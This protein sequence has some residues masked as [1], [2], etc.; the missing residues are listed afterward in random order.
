[1]F[2]QPQDSSV[3]SELK[4]HRALRDVKSEGSLP[5][6][7]E[8]IS[9]SR[10]PDPPGKG[11]AMLVLGVL[12]LAALIYQFSQMG[13]SEEKQSAPVA[14]G[15][16]THVDELRIDDGK[17]GRVAGNLA[18]PQP[19]SGPKPVELTPEDIAAASLP[20]GVPDELAPQMALALAQARRGPPHIARKGLLKLAG[21]VW[22]VPE[23]SRPAV[24]ERALRAALDAAK[25]DGVRGIALE[26]A[27]WMREGATD[28][29]RAL[30]VRF[31][32]HAQIALEAPDQSDGAI[33]FLHGDNSETTR[34]LLAEIIDSD[35]RPLW[36]RVA[37]ARAYAGGSPTEAM[38][39]IAQDP[40]T[41]LILRI[42][43]GGAK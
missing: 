14:P 2:K 10:A 6:R 35:S 22:N 38:T 33:L 20:E 3:Q 13:G 29:E 1:M 42:A 25:R 40:A 7:I 30:L 9:R 18:V 41:P 37:A 8:A 17:T 16:A 31:V 4:R 39:K 5:Q 27:S 23:D 32:P 11:I 12:V 28:K 15:D 19:D 21:L 36:Q 43:L 24:R 26:A 34:M